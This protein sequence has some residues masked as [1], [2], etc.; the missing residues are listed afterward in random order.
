MDCSI[1]NRKGCNYCLRSKDIPS[2]NSHFGLHIND[3]DKS[4][5][6]CFNDV[7]SGISTEVIIDINYCPLCGRKL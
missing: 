7:D 2:Y 1:T 4:I 3:E 5:E 6:I